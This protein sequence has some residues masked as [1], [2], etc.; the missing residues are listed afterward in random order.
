MAIARRAHALRAKVLRIAI[1]PGVS[2][3]RVLPGMERG[4][5]DIAGVADPR[6]RRA[7]KLVARRPDARTRRLCNRMTL[8]R[9]RPSDARENRCGH[10]RK[11]QTEAS[12][13]IVK[14]N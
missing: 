6:I 8:M 4:A 7:F 10:R 1:L 9:W 5:K 3:L 13:W 12:Y 14:R 2:G 11:Q